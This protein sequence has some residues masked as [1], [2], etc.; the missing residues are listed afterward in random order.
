ME[1][2]IL[3]FSLLLVLGGCQKNDS[4]TTAET[5]SQEILNGTP[6]SASEF[7][8]VGIIKGPNFICTGTL[9]SS[10]VVL[11]AGHCVVDDS[12]NLAQ[13]KFS[14]ETTYS[15][16]TN[17]TNITSIRRNAS[18]DIAIIKL[19]LPRNG[20][21]TSE[22]SLSPLTSTQLNRNVEIV[23]YGNSA[24]SSSG[25]TQRDSGSGVK[26]K[27]VS[28]LSRFDSG[29]S[30]LVSKPSTSKQV[31]CPGDSGGPLF[32]NT[33][34]RRQLYGVASEVL[35]RGYCSTVSESYH[36]H[37]S[38]GDTRTWLLNN[39]AAW[40]K[41]VSIYR[42]MDNRGNYIYDNS[43]TSGTLVFKILDVPGTFSNATCTTP[44]VRCKTSQGMNYLSTN[45]CGTATFEKLL[46][47][48][49]NGN[50]TS[51]SPASSFD[52][53]RVDNTTTGASISTSQAAAQSLVQQNSQWR[54]SGFQGVYV[55][56]PN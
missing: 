54:I 4:Q 23:G 9:I 35:W 50:R 48:A 33:V 12:G 5:P 27:G 55:L 25:G 3:G 19:S 13:L 24:T 44:L 26:R 14:L 41:K 22:I 16:A 1:K 46:G 43:T 28:L 37:V 49:C 38:F 30:R 20:I 34:G 2:W 31:I 10:D 21:E 42:R 29:N 53:W 32:F 52:L 6:I 36:S 18:K 39:L 56:S 17:W 45:T 11:T 51:Q 7:P 47:Y 40:A 8:S 15:T